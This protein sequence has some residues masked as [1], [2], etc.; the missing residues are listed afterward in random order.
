MTTN[1]TKLAVNTYLWHNG[2]V[3]WVWVSE[4]ELYEDLLYNELHMTII[5]WRELWLQFSLKSEIHMS[6][7]RFLIKL[8]VVSFGDI[9]KFPLNIPLSD[10]NIGSSESSIKIRT[11]VHFV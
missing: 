11:E 4:Y 3:S 10:I 5:Y 9:L 2:G 6:L 8:S 1:E 7:I